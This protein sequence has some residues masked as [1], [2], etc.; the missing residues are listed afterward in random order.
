MNNHVKII[1]SLVFIWVFGLACQSKMPLD[2]ESYQIARLKPQH[3]SGTRNVGFAG[4]HS[5]TLDAG[6]SVAIAEI[7]GPAVITHIHMTKHLGY[8]HA[9]W[10]R[11]AFQL[12]GETIMPFF[13]VNGRGQLLGSS[14]RSVRMS[15][16]SPVFRG[17]WR[18]TTKS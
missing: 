18:E 7:E 9:T 15:R 10:K 6:Q 2:D 17:L 12:D 11:F 14:W 16:I 8:L 5:E 4:A 3:K 1:I 13:R